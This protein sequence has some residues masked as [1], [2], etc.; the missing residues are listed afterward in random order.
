MAWVRETSSGGW[1]GCYRDPAGKTRS[2]SF[3]KNE[4]GKARAWAADQEAAMRGGTYVEPKAGKTTLADLYDEVHAAR[5]YAPAT[6]ALHAAL[7]GKVEDRAHPLYVLR[8]RKAGTIMRDE[9]NDALTR[10]TAVAVRDKSRLLVS[11]LFNYGMEKH[12][13]RENP[14]RKPRATG[15]RAEKMAAGRAKA[16]KRYLTDGELALLREAVPDRY[17]ALVH[18]MAR[19]GLRPGEALALEVGKFDPMRRR[20]TIDTSVS[21]FTKTGEAREVT[22]PAVIT[23]EIAGHLAK[24]SDPTNSAALIFRPA[25]RGCSRLAG[26]DTSSGE[27]SRE[28]DWTR[29]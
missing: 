2:R 15:T 8:H 25:R 5:Q 18:L 17:A 10:I 16:R 27:Q 13:L 7:W 21:E 14:A 3:S 19:V 4:K 28:L 29:T 23:E 1:K 20:L 22:L 26:S 24:F 9:V 11:T 12:G 6:L